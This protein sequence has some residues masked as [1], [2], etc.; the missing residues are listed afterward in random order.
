MASCFDRSYYVL[1]KHPVILVLLLDDFV[2]LMQYILDV[3]TS[4][5]IC[6]AIVYL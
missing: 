5:H 2:G 1:W 6:T 4:R 3:E